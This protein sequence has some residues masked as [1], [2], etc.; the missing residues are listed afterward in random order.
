M[1][2]LRET[3]NVVRL[4][5]RARNVR[6]PLHDDERA[7]LS[8]GR[9]EDGRALLHCHAGCATEGILARAGLTWADL[10]I[11]NGNGRQIAATYDYTDEKNKVLFQSVRTEPKGF[12]QRRPDGAGGWINN[13]GKV[14]RVLF[15]L[16]A[17]QGQIVVYIAEG[18]KDALALRQLGLVATTNAGGAGKWRDAYTQQLKAAGVESVVVL[19]DHDD[20]GRR[21]AVEVARSCH[22]AGLHTKLVEL[23]GL[24]EHGDATD[25]LTTQT[26]DDLLSITK[27]SDTRPQPV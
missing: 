17:L 25:Y 1:P 19:P 27:H 10:H 22:A 2:D 9:G 23:P 15:G 5:G 13:L 4:D 26:R 11:T 21:H 12:F 6:C 8:I 24:P 14:R 18:E 3:I 20:P 7:S 16:P